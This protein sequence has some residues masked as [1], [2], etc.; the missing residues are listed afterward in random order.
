MYSPVS[1]PSDCHTCHKV[2]AC[3][4]DP[5]HAL[6]CQG[7]TGKEITLR[8]NCVVNDLYRGIQNC[9]GSG[10]KEPQNLSH[11]GDATRPDLQVVI[12]GEQVLIDVTIRNPT[13]PSYYDVK[14]GSAEEQLYST[15]VAENQKCK[16]YSDMAKSQGAKFVPFAVEMYGGMGKSAKQLIKLINKSA[17]DQMLMWPYQQLIQNL[18]GDIAISIQRG[19]AIAILAGYNS[20]LSKSASMLQQG[21]GDNN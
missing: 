21:G 15:K 12:G 13:C 18:K 17:R 16:K 2:D 7:Q 5:F 20:A 4:N 14:G 9:G 10:L 8:H 1:L 11:K 19:N 6:S 3:A